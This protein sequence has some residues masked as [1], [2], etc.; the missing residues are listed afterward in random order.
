MVWEF[1]NQEPQE[2]IDIYVDAN[3]AGCRCTRKS[4]SGGCAMLG[5]HCPKI[6]PK[7]QSIIAK[8]SGESELYGVI[9]GSSEG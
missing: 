9:K 8:Y 2:A 1:P 6:W 5:K 7:T 4:T 3:L